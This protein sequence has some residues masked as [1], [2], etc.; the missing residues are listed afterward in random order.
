[1]KR[2]ASPTP[3]TTPRASLL[4]VD[5]DASFRRDTANHLRLHG[6]HVDESANG[7]EGL[8]RIPE[9]LPDVILCEM[10]LPGLCGLQLLEAVRCNPA[11]STTAF[12]LLCGRDP[13]AN[14]RAAM[15]SGAD[16]VLLKPA[17]R[18]DLIASIEARLAHRR[19]HQEQLRRT[20]AD[21]RFIPDFN[22]HAPLIQHLDLTPCEAE[23]LLWVAQG[24]SNADIATILGKSEKT[25][26][27]TLG[28]VF[29]KLGLESRTA[30]A[31]RAVEVLGRARLDRNFAPTP[32]PP[33]PNRPARF[34]R[35][36][37]APLPFTTSR[38]PTHSPPG[39]AAP[40]GSRL[41]S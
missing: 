15:N 3:E 36:Q 10:H 2:P 26:K 33:V 14:I 35:H 40:A 4:L 5:D 11:T 20:L 28:H 6:F 21:L 29:A 41:T 22:S 19:L 23:T 30:A 9:T 1:M 24:K 7:V 31:L 8:R 38:R 34:A 25:V 39:S 27:K 16:D 12:I 37:F 13:A 32:L 17:T 18:T